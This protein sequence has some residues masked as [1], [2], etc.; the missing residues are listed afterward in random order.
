MSSIRCRVVKPKN[1]EELKEILHIIGVEPSNIGVILPKSTFFTILVEDIPLKEAL[2]LKQEMLSK[3]GECAVSSGVVNLEVEKSSVLLCGTKRQ[4]TDLTKKLF[5]QPLELKELGKLLNN[6]F[7]DGVYSSRLLKFRNRGYLLGE[8]T[9]IMGIINVTPDSFSDGGRYDD[10]DRA[11]RGA[12]QMVEEGADI[13]DVGGESTRPGAVPVGQEEELRRVIPVIE[14]IREH[15]D[16]PLSIDTYKSEVAASAL[17]AGADMINDVWGGLK[18]PAMLELAASSGLPICLMHNR[19]EPQ[20]KNLI[21]DIV[22]DLLARAEDALLAG[23]PMENIILDPG[24]GFAKNAEQNLEVMRLLGEITALGYPVM[25]GTSRKSMIG[26]VLD[27][28]VEER[29][30][31]TAATVAYAITC[32]VDIVRVH[33]VLEMSRV[34]AMTD[35]IVRGRDFSC[36]Q[37]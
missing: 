4:F 32:G 27:L 9:L 14:A 36:P 22:N 15:S 5:T 16:I 1:E 6:T 28:A 3:G 12:L 20:Y 11:L 8:R 34:A 17:E 31:G 7:E 13:I 19:F 24:I 29:L 25:L 37:S 35:A 2:I 10:I 18:D 21:S 30:E 23:V 26:K 33:D